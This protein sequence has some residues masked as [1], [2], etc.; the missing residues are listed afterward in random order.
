MIV[1]VLCMFMCVRVR[2]RVFACVRVCVSVCVRVFVC[3]RVRSWFVCV[4]VCRCVF[5]RVRVIP[6][7][8]VTVRVPHPHDC[9][10]V[11]ETD[12][13]HVGICE[14]RDLRTYT[15][16]CLVFLRRYEAE[17][18]TFYRTFEN[19]HKFAKTT[20]YETSRL[21]PSHELRRRLFSTVIVARLP[22]HGKA[23][24]PSFL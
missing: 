20:A 13:P 17:H 1:I 22:R 14:C 11:P 9:Q 2:S 4:C 5:G 24:L 6:C 3:V 10:M 16:H 15:R 7:V 18:L 23:A 8:F 21:K 12:I 19:V